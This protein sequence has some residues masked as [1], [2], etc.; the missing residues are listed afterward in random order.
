MSYGKTPSKELTYLQ[1]LKIAEK[2]QDD[3]VLWQK[4]TEWMTPRI[5]KGEVSPETGVKEYELMEVA[6][7]E[8]R[9]GGKAKEME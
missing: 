6:L 1:C 2:Y 3:D 5:E 8:N 7:K 4:F 9:N